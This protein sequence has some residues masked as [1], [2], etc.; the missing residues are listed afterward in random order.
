MA[1]I[2]E[3]LR[4]ERDSYRYIQA[5]ISCRDG[6]GVLNRVR[7]VRRMGVRHSV[8]Q[9]HAPRHGFDEVQYRLV[10]CLFH[11]L[12]LHARCERARPAPAVLRLSLR[13]AGCSDRLADADRVCEWFESFDRSIVNSR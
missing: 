11:L 7:G 10:L 2:R 5:L 4:N 8:A 12:A 9:G 3:E 6:G 13:F 1:D